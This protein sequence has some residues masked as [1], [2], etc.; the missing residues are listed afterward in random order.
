[1]L[2]LAEKT[3]LADKKEHADF[4][5][6]QTLRLHGKTSKLQVKSLSPLFVDQNFA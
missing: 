3:E 6:E 4:R 2:I 5:P 1:M